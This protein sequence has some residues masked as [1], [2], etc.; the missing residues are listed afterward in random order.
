MFISK[1]SRPLVFF[2]SLG[3]RLKDQ[4]KFLLS[5]QSPLDGQ[6][7]ELISSNKSKFPRPGNPEKDLET[8]RGVIRDY[9]SRRRE[10]VNEGMRIARNTANRTIANSILRDCERI[11]SDLANLEQA[12]IEL[13]VGSQT[14]SHNT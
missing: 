7:F 9:F 6:I 12:L 1:M 4:L 11:L 3:K 10:E 13:H 8:L 14:E 2:D 5:M